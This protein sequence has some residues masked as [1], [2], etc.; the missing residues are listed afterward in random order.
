MLGALPEEESIWVE[1]KTSPILEQAG[2]ANVARNI[3]GLANRLPDR[4]ATTAEGYGYI[5]VGVEPGNLEGV[6]PVEHADLENWLTP[7]L[8]PTGPQWVPSYVQDQGKHVLL[9]SVDPPRW[10]DPI[11]VPRPG[12]AIA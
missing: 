11:F 7:Y 10:G 8:G 1:W 2:R 9:I 5:L 6:T 12:R 3:L 4:A